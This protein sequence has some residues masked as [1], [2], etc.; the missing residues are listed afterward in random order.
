LSIVKNITSTYTSQIIN[1]LLG[2]VSSIFI[3]RILGAEGRGEYALFIN[4]LGIATIFLGFGL[5]SAVIYFISGNKMQPEKILPTVL[6]FNVVMAFIVL[7]ILQLLF[8]LNINQFIFPADK[9]SKIY[10]VIFVMQFLITVINAGTTAVLNAKKYFVA[11]SMVTG[12]ATALGTML[13]IRFYYGIINIETNGFKLIIFINLGLS[14]L[15]GI[16]IVALYKKYIGLKLRGLLKRN[17]VRSLFT[18]SLM[19][20]ACNSI[21]FL[22]YRA[23][24][25]FVEYYRDIKTVGIYSLAVSLA[26]LMWILPNAIGAVMFSYIA[27]ATREKAIEYTVFFTKLS[28][29][30]SLCM[31]LT[32]YI[33]FYYALPDIYGYEFESAINLIG[34]LFLGIVPFSIAIIFGSFFAG[35]GNLRHNLITSSL[36]FIGAIIFY[37]L[38]IP[39]Y[40]ATGAA[41]ASIISYNIC[42]LYMF[43]A[44]NKLSGYRILN[45]FVVNKFDITLAKSVI[46]NWRKGK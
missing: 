7:I 15:Q 17:E 46:K 38:L 2:F 6:L 11:I 21:Q 32:A 45:I 23:D 3:T 28:F 24:L 18:F 43:Y 14:F 4:A 8:I 26:Q 25:W 31:G 40:G 42:T 19:A 20:Y 37:I 12:I 30:A 36:G 35:T 1:I 10:Q 9:Q 29:Y 44:F 33:I 27:S 22:S 34:I 16:F 13:Y 5:P 41:W 39:R